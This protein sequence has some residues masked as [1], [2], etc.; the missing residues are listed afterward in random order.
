MGLKGKIHEICSSV[1]DADS[2][3]FI[4]RGE[5]LAVAN[6]EDGKVALI[7]LASLTERNLTNSKK[8]QLHSYPFLIFLDNSSL[9]IVGFTNCILCI[10]RNNIS[11]NGGIS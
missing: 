7:S 4:K 5:F 8:V 11:V 10:E 9:F 6:F 3:L 2:I 1:V